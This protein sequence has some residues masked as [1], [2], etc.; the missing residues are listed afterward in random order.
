[1]ALE[2]AFAQG[3]ARSDAEGAQS[4][5]V[6]IWGVDE[7]NWD[8]QNLMAQDIMGAQCHVDVLRAGAI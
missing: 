6:A 7:V 8:E 5:L 1:M 4:M 2:A 3:G